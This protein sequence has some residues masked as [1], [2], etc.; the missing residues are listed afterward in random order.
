MPTA[1]PDQSLTALTAAERALI[2]RRN[3]IDSALK[4]I[5]ATRAQLAKQLRAADPVLRF[6]LSLHPTQAKPTTVSEPRKRAKKARPKP[7]E[8]KVTEGKATKSPEKKTLGVSPV[9]AR[10]L[11]LALSKEPRPVDLG[12][13]LELTYGPAWRSHKVSRPKGPGAFE[14]VSFEEDLAASHSTLRSMLNQAARQLELLAGS[15]NWPKRY[16][17]TPG[18]KRV[19]TA[20]RVK[21]R[22]SELRPTLKAWGVLD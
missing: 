16:V 20:L 1:E 14:S 2:E 19:Y 4:T 5:R 13:A 18:L 6:A 12:S 10:V 22:W 11:R 17:L 8:E 3:L 15:K 21:S 9:A 7:A